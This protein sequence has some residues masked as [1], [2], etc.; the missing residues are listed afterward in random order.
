[1]SLGGLAFEISDVVDLDDKPVPVVTDVED[2]VSIHI[3]GIFEDLS[4]LVEVSP[5]CSFGDLVPRG[6]FIGCVLI[7]LSSF[8]QAPL[9]NDM[10][11]YLD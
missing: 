8:D 10:H 5:F 11:R 3:V 2:D 4:Q 9:R 7:G 6:E 1:M